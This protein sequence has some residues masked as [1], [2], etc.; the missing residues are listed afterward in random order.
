MLQQSGFTLGTMA[1]F[2]LE[3]ALT[4][5]IGGFLMEGLGKAGGVLGKTAKVTEAATEGELIANRAARETAARDIAQA[6]EK[7]V[8]SITSKLSKAGNY[9]GDMIPG[10]ATVKDISTA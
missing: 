6:G 7:G 9:I 8:N 3:E 2:A 1:Q 10:A 4:Q 5:G